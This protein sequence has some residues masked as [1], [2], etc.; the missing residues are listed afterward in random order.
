M[1][2]LS[3]VLACDATLGFEELYDVQVRAFNG[4]PVRNL[5]HLATVVQSC[6]E[7][8]MRFDLDMQAWPPAPPCPCAAC[9]WPA[10]RPA[11]G[12]LL[13]QPGCL[14]ATGQQMTDTD[15]TACLASV[16]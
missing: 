8:F 10:Q 12:P 6:R 16:S 9:A 14:L 5:R 4:T 11:G 1:V 7:P 2:I 13:A 3:Q 15:P